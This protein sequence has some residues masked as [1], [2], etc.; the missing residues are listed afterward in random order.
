MSHKGTWT[1]ACTAMAHAR[2]H[3]WARKRGARVATV[4]HNWLHRHASPRHTQTD[5]T[6]SQ[7]QPRVAP[8]K[9]TNPSRN[10]KR[11]TKLGEEKGARLRSPRDGRR[12]RRASAHSNFT[13]LMGT[14]VGDP[15]PTGTSRGLDLRRWT[16]KW[17][18]C[19]AKHTGTARKLDSGLK[20]KSSHDPKHPLAP[21]YPA[22]HAVFLVPGHFRRTFR[23]VAVVCVCAGKPQFRTDSQ[24]RWQTNGGWGLGQPG[25]RVAM[26]PSFPHT[27]SPKH[28][29]NMSRRE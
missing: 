14:V 2:E 22:R 29:K 5:R 18:R 17:L 19:E 16:S 23:G 12:R 9:D 13:G 24:F 7:L 6:G 20:R 26:R 4:G 15:G 25:P 3:V 1:A 11:V 28:R 10:D 27:N 8:T 21:T